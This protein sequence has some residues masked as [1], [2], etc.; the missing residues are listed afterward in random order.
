MT[1]NQSPTAEVPNQQS[2]SDHSE[3]ATRIA[4]RLRRLAALVSIL[5]LTLLVPAATARA[6]VTAAPG[7]VG[8]VSASCNKN[9][10]SLSVYVTQ[11]QQYGPG[12]QQMQLEIWVYSYR[13]NTWNNVK[14]GYDNVSNAGTA[15]S[16]WTASGLPT[17]QYA[18]YARYWWKA[19]NGWIQGGEFVNLYTQVGVGTLV[20]NVGV[21]SSICMT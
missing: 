6:D 14:L 5:T 12:G 13:I 9:L 3:P 18:V 21:N 2:P 7:G 15:T 19:S 11:N 4:T 10:H 8:V 17:G 1:T 20:S 16:L